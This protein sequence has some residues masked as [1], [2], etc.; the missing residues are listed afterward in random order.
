MIKAKESEEIES[1][2]HQLQ[3]KTRLVILT[4]DIAKLKLGHSRQFHGFPLTLSAEKN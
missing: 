3:E 2:V 1:E 4:Y